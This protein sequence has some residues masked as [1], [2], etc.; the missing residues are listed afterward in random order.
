MAN[1]QK[2]FEIKYFIRNSNTQY[3]RVQATNQQV[4]A[5]IA[6]SQLPT[7]TFIGQPRQIR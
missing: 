4:A 1:N 7:A 6:K 5:E 2:E 3:L